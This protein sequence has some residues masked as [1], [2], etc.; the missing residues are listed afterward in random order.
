MRACWQLL[1]TLAQ[2]QVDATLAELPMPLRERAQALPVT[3]ERRPNAAHRRDG[4]AAD[5][6]GLF[7]G[8]EFACEETSALPLPPQIILFLEN[9]WDFAE[10]DEEIYCDE[11]HTTYLHE[12]G[13]Y[14]GLD[15]DDLYDRGLD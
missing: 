6:L 10:A 9:L 14:L 8:P 1:R 4:I 15:E 11:V 13:H 12:L 5:T 2:E 3:F 7:V